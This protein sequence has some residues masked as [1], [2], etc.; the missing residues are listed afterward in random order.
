[1]PDEPIFEYFVHV[2]RWKDSYDGARCLLLY[3]VKNGEAE[4][5]DVR[6]MQ[7]QLDLLSKALND[8]LYRI[9]LRYVRGE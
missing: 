5:E 3:M 6:L 2:R 9:P 4:G 7:D 8:E 1:M